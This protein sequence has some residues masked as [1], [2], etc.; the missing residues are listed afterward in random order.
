MSKLNSLDNAES[1]ASLASLNPT[2]GPYNGAPTF[3]KMESP[4][5]P[6]PS[7]RDDD[8]DKNKKNKTPED[9]VKEPLVP[10]PAQDE[11]NP[12]LSATLGGVVMPVKKK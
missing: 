3:I 7:D 5:E 4:P 12:P 6:K 9:A 11:I 2:A 1:S 8:S 10:V